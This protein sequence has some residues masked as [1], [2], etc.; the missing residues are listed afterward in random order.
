MLVMESGAPGEDKQDPSSKIENYLGFPM[1]VS[2]QE[3]TSR[4]Y[5]Q[6]QK[7]GAE[8]Q[9]ATGAAQLVCRGSETPLKR[10]QESE[11]TPVRYRRD[12]RGVPEAGAA[13]SLAI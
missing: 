6:A 10:H 8:L 4:A 7:F 2:G 13:Q 9:V 12:G 1:G 3:L 5:T 11:S